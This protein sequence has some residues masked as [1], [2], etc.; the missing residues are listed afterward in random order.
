MQRFISLPSG[1]HVTLGNSGPQAC[2]LLRTQSLSLQTVDPRTAS[3]SPSSPSSSNET[4]PLPALDL[5]VYA[6]ERTVEGHHA[7]KLYKLKGWGRRG[8]AER[9]RGRGRRVE[10]QEGR[11]DRKGRRGWGKEEDGPR[12]PGGRPR[13]RPSKV[14][15]LEGQVL[16][17]VTSRPRGRNQTT[18]RAFFKTVQMNQV[19][20]LLWAPTPPT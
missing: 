13:A 4:F 11:E 7:N 19:I 18:A 5:M 14:C 17:S 2:S 16:R 15:F 9:G 8:V 3:G 6:H 10:K 1:E 12:R 20:W